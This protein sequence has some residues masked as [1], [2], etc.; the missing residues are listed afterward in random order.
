MKQRFRAGLI[1]CGALGR[2]HADCVMRLDGIE[3]VAFC[4]RDLAR[5][6]A[7]CREY[8]GQYATQDA[9]AVIEDPG[10]D[11]VYIV[12][13]HD[14]HAPYCIRAADAGKHILVEKPLAL[15]VEECRAIGQAVQRNGIKLFTAFKMRYYDMIRKAR[16]LIPQPLLVSMQMMDN[17]WADDF[18]ASDP[19]TGGGNVLSQGCH[20]CDILR[21]VTG[22]EPTEVFAA[23]GNYYTSTGVVDNLCATFRFANGAAGNW[24]QGD[25][26]CPP[27]MSKFFLQLFAEGRSVTLSDRLTTLTYREG[28]AEPQIFRG[29]ETG[30]LEENRAFLDCLLHDTS[31]AIDH[32]DGLTATLMVLQAVH[33]LQ[34]GKPEPIAALVRESH[35]GAGQQ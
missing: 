6:E 2:V 32:V 26:S 17:R 27:L 20:S 9:L 16:E 34:S 22:S 21:F 35:E 4:D 33:S 5:A 25:A 30:F 11:A 3:M 1:G 14:T 31:P 18:W 28:K 13:W 10:L 29:S 8:G 12:T 7:L 15:T 19:I 23:G 24:I